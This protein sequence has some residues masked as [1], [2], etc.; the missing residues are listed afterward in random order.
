MSLSLN[1]A[2]YEMQHY[3][4]NTFKT[5]I[6]YT[7]KTRYMFLVGGPLN[8]DPQFSMSQIIKRE[9]AKQVPIGL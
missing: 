8:L 6:Y 3:F 5:Y 9:T 4:K 7:H 2:I 1:G